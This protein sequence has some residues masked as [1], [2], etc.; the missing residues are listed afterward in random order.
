MCFIVSVCLGYTL[1]QPKT[2]DLLHD[3][4][5]LYVFMLFECWIG[6]IQVPMEW[7]NHTK[8]PTL[9]IS[10]LQMNLT[11]QCKHKNASKYP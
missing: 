2:M 3:P 6:V 10:V 4:I 8:L 9:C 11:L 5:F 1:E 7:E